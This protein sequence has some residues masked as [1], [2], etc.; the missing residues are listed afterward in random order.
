MESKQ[1]ALPN[2][3]TKGNTDVDVEMILDMDTERQQVLNNSIDTML[4]R[5][6]KIQVKYD[7]LRGNAHT[8]RTDSYRSHAISSYPG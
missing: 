1:Q 4:L 7:S 3:E 6:E 2:E 8:F 5:F